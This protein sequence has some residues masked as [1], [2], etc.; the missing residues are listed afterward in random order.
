MKFSHWIRIKDTSTWGSIGLILSSLCPINIVYLVESLVPIIIVVVR[1]ISWCST[2]HYWVAS[3][4]SS[5]CTNSSICSCAYS[6]CSPW[7]K[8]R[9][10]SFASLAKHFLILNHFVSIKSPP[11]SAV[12]WKVMRT[13]S[14]IR[15]TWLNLWVLPF[16]H[17]F[18]ITIWSC[19]N[20]RVYI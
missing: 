18:I 20:L 19:I 10:W 3:W 1:C 2:Y 11:E 14:L 17:D 5:I 13:R 15:T 4:S 9:S 6:L 7:C 16:K 12:S 8:H